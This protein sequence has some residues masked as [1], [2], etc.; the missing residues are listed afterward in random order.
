MIETL[1]EHKE[2]ITED[3]EKYIT[4][5]IRIHKLVVLGEG[6]KL[7]SRFYS[8]LSLGVILVLVV[9]FVSIGGAIITGEVLGNDAAGFFIFAGVLLMFGLFLYLFIRRTAERFVLKSLQDI[10]FAK[11]ENPEDEED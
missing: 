10:L 9:L 5:R 3:L 2:K 8:S 4:A 7:I 1:N 6:T 11:E